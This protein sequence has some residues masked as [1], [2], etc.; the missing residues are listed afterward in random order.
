MAIE[1]AHQLQLSYDENTLSTMF[2]N[3]FG[4]FF[5]RSNANVTVNPAQLPPSYPP[6]SSVAATTSASNPVAAGGA[7]QG[8]TQKAA[9]AKVEEAKGDKAAVGDAKGRS[10]VHFCLKFDW[11]DMFLRIYFLIRN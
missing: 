4:G 8:Q 9:P 10:N 6:P 11:N 5:N 3:T 2:K 1:F 7:S